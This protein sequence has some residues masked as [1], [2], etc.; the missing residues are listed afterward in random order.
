MMN[1]QAVN[2]GEKVGGYV[3][4]IG[5]PS[6]SLAASL[7]YVDG[8]IGSMIAELDA[9]G[10]TDS[11]MVVVTAKHG[12]TPIDVSLRHA[13]DPALIDATVNSVQPGLLAQETPDTISLI[14]LHDHSQTPAVVAA[15]QANATNL[16]IDTIYSGDAL[17]NAFNGTLELSPNRRADIIIEP[18][19]GVIYTTSSIS[20]KKC[21]HGSFNDESTHVPLIVAGPHVAAGTITTPVDLRQVAPTIVKALQLKSHDLDAVRLEHTHRLPVVDDDGT[22]L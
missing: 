5:T 6:A 18:K 12:Q 4:A 3:D 21:E 9:Q 20:S 13:I 2:I 11:T 16:G 8:A 17:D 19:E 15:L 10:L 14:W 7:D 1:F 22:D